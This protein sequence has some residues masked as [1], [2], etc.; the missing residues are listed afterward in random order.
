MNT[1]SADIA[2][3]PFHEYFY[4]VA[5]QFATPERPAYQAP[6]GYSGATFLASL[7]RHIGEFWV[8]AYVRYD[9]L[10]G[11]VFDPSP[12]VKQNYALAGG[13]GFAWV[14]AESGTKVQTPD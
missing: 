6:G 5:P 11:A 9:N 2:T 1:T 10:S 4:S 7:S 13:I 12:L 8:G 3:K 14:F